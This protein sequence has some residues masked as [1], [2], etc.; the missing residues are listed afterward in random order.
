[1]RSVTDGYT[2]AGGKLLS[3]HPTDTYWLGRARRTTGPKRLAE[4]ALFY[5]KA[6][7][8]LP[9]EMTRLEL[10]ETYY[11]M[12]CY[13]A[14]DALILKVLEEDPSAGQAWYLLGLTALARGDEITSQNAFDRCMRLSPLSQAAVNS[15]TMLL[16]YAWSR[17]E[18][19][20][21]LGFRSDCLLRKAGEKDHGP[22]RAALCILACLR[23]PGP[24]ALLA[25]VTEEAR[26][27]PAFCLA[28]LPYVY[29]SRAL[30]LDACL[31]GAICLSRLGRN[32]L[33]CLYAA[34]LMAASAA[35]VERL[36]KAALEA[37]QA[38]FILA[39]LDGLLREAPF[40]SGLMLLKALCLEKKGA[41]KEAGALRAAAGRT[42][43]EGMPAGDCAGKLKRMAV[44]HNRL[45][46]GQLNRLL[47]RL[48]V[49][50]ADLDPSALYRIA[51]PLYRGMNRDARRN[52][53]KTSFRPWDTAFALCVAL[54]TGRPEAAPRLPEG[55][56]RF[57]LRQ[58]RRMDRG[59]Y[60][61]ARSLPSERGTRGG[62]SKRGST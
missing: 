62:I 2:N 39:H 30:R 32:P 54:R 42:A 49:F 50:R 3:L 55:Q 18:R 34:S 27:H 20:P 59:L 9:S 52:M 36:T 19:I 16:D 4:K 44:Y 38:D 21:V 6:L 1:M 26:E 10:A 53:E 24:R 14:A 13:D 35:D 28:L 31:C 11:R 12:Q 43:P 23:H 25:L 5:R 7:E 48:A 46:S 29:K 40:S 57:I 17:G 33:P 61:F 56:R 37:G 45:R 8:A 41:L 51:V 22:E 47:H 58:V 60:R 15:Q